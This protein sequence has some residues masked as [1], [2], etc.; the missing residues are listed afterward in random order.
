MLFLV[1]RVSNRSKQKGTGFENLVVEFLNSKKIP[2]ERR[3][4]AGNNDKGDVLIYASPSVVVECKAE[5]KFDL[6]SYL[7]ELAVELENSGGDFGFVAL[8]APRKSVE[9]CYA[10]VS[11]D[12]MA[13]LLKI[14]LDKKGKK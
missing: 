1:V 8:K 4:L 7:K 12:F 3:A 10:I 2:C 11:L 9:N 6:A 5:A 14:Y 13:D